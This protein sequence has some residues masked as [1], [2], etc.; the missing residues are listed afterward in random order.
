MRS[1]LIPALSTLPCLVAFAQA[2][3]PAQAEAYVKKAIVFAKENGMEKLIQETNQASGKFHVA[4]GSELYIFIY[5]MEGNCKAIGYNT[6]ALV[7]KNRLETRDPDGKYFLKEMLAVVKGKGKGWV[8]YKYPNPLNN[9][10]EAKT[11]YVEMCEG[12][13]VGSGV[14]K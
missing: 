13:L 11:S 6:G 10:I 2:P 7:G 12:L 14:Y 9:K 1:L 3:T 4:T 8:D 5:D